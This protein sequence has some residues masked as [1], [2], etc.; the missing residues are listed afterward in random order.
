[1]TEK[2]FEELIVILRRIAFAVE[3]INM[4]TPPITVAIPPGYIAQ[5]Y[6]CSVCHT[7]V[8]PGRTHSCAGYRPSS[9]GNV[10]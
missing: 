1:M 5:S 4:K 8:L 7:W 2:Q 6:Q 10:G 3:G 9:G